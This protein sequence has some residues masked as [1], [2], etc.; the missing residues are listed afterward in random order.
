MANR[1]RIVRAPAGEAPLWVR[2]RWVGLDLPLLLDREV[3]TRGVGVLTGKGRDGLLNSII[4]RLTGKTHLLRG[5]V[6]KVDDALALLAA[7]S[8][9]A[10]EWWRSEAP[11]MIGRTFVFDTPACQL[12]GED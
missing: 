8:P 4:W 2:E 12:L 5:Y 3:T 10:A 11:H 9:E 7:S 6:V 1:I